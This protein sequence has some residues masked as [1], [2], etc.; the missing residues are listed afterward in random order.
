M[1]NHIHVIDLIFQA[2][3]QGREHGFRARN[4]PDHP[5]LEELW[6]S[7]R[8]LDAWFITWSDEVNEESLLERVAFNFVGG[9]QGVMTREQ[10]LLH[11]VHHTSYHRGY[12]ADLFKQ[13]P[14]RVPTTDLPV[15]LR[16]V[17][18]EPI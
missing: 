9:G 4:T 18:Q 7:Q 15:F 11:V 13:I 8:Q 5:P 17:P 14:A 1:L 12:I 3:L 16:D 6:Q 2:H 10:M